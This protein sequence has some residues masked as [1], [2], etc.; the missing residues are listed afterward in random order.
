MFA[1]VKKNREMLFPLLGALVFLFVLGGLGV[2]IGNKNG[3]GSKKSEEIKVVD[4]VE[5]TPQIKPEETAENSQTEQK[6]L[7]SNVFFLEPSPAEIID[8]IEG[9]D[10]V[11]LDEKAKEF[12]GLKVMWP[13][14][15]FKYEVT[16]AGE[17]QVFLD[18]SEDGF[19]ISVVCD[20]DISKYPQIVEV[21]EG[22][23]LWLAGEIVGLS[24]EGTGQFLIKT[25]QIR[26][27]G[28]IDRPP[29]APVYEESS[30]SEE[31]LEQ[32]SEEAVSE[33]Q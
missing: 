32:G 24:P 1:W 9:L 31:R 13:L 6:K 20:V 16:E 26:F 28:T 5:I 2:F 23:L 22:E 18:V 29:T 3:S 25:E 21:K 33:E 19:G 15:F 30:Q 11:Q 14:Y 27:G 4:R 12:P 17:H 7:E 10:P 8:T